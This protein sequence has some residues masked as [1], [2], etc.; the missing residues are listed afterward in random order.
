MPVASAWVTVR[1]ART[2]RPVG[3]GIVVA[4][5]H[6]LTCAHVVSAAL[7]LPKEQRQV[8]DDAAVAK[9][10]LSLPGHGGRYADGPA[11]IVGWEAPRADPRHDRW[12]GDLALLAVAGVGTPVELGETELYRTLQTWHGEGGP[13]TQV[14]VVVKSRIGARWLMLDAAHAA[15][16]VREGFSGAPLWDREA[17]RVVGLVVSAESRRPRAY[18]I[19]AGR[20]RAFLDASGLRP[21]PLSANLGGSERERRG[22]LLDALDALWHGLPPERTHRLG[23]RLAEELAL[24]VQPAA[25]EAVAES[26]LAHPRG[27]LVLGHLLDLMG[28]PEPGRKDVLA[29]LTGLGPQRILLPVEYEKLCAELGPHGYRELLTAAGRSGCLVGVPAAT[30]CDLSALVEYLEARR[31]RHAHTV[32]HLVRAVEEAAA[33]RGSAGGGLRAWSSAVAT[34]HKVPRKALKECRD[35]AL[36]RAAG[37]SE[38]RPVVRVRLVRAVRPDVYEYEIRAYDGTDCQ[39]GSWY[40]DEPVPRDELCSQLALAVEE[41]EQ[42]VASVDV[43]FIIEDGDF[44]RPVDRWPVPSAEAGPRALGLDRP[45]VLRG[46]PMKRT[47]LWQERWHQRAGG[48]HAPLVLYDREQAERELPVRLD[49]A[50]V[51]LCCSRERRAPLLGICRQQGIPVVLW[52][53]G[54]HGGHEERILEPFVR[55]DWPY[56]LLGNVREFRVAAGTDE[57]HPG[58]NLALLWEDPRWS[59]ARW[60][61]TLGTGNRRWGLGQ[62]GGAA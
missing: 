10:R 56:R 11:R 26:V 16:T 54:E 41:V 14:D 40:S 2:E 17:C 30:V 48:G 21:Q 19:A 38:H 15:I 23:R 4:D 55:E 51:I 61:G 59:P 52:C 58:A 1:S 39:T 42:A 28:V 34:R 20:M 37:Q 47:A 9:L 33:G 50:C 6:V 46:R 43:E 62:G 45:V 3:A 57:A 13:G 36:D 25:P 27:P 18:G 49:V 32:P 5:G 60:Q 35:S 29:A 44:E 7:G 12:D 31:S 24:W 53:R 22:R 8:P